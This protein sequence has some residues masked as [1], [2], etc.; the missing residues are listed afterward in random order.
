MLIVGFGRFAGMLNPDDVP[1]SVAGGGVKEDIGGSG[2]GA[3]GMMGL[4]GDSLIALGDLAGLEALGG[5]GVLG[6]NDTGKTGPEVV[7][8]GGDFIMLDGASRGAPVEG[9]SALGGG[10][11]S[12]VMPSKGAGSDFVFF[13][14]AGIAGFEVISLLP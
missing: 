6:L 9:C 12:G 10:S 1:L 14:S 5:V 13:V 2:G 3:S 11:M 8:G 4:A 7:G